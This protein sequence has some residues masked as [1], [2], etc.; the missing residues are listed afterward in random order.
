MDYPT[1]NTFTYDQRERVQHVLR[2]GVWVSA[3]AAS[4]R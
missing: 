4:S 2:Y 3:L 1:G